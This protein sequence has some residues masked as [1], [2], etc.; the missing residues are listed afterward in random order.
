MATDAYFVAI[1]NWTF[2]Y[3]FLDVYSSSMI[4]VSVLDNFSENTYK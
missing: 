4:T 2:Y 1:R 3:L